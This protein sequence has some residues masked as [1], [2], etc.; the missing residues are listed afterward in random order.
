VKPSLLFESPQSGTGT[1]GED[2][3]RH[4]ALDR[5]AE[6]FCPDGERRKIFLQILASPLTDEKELTFRREIR[7][8]LRNNPDTEPAL[9]EWTKGFAELVRT[10][11]HLRKD[12][13]RE[14]GSA[15]DAIATANNLR[16]AQAVCLKRAILFLRDALSRL[17]GKYESKGILRLKAAL[18]ESA[19]RPE[20]EEILDLC[21]KIE[22]L[23][24]NE[25]EF[26]IVLTEDGEAGQCETVYS[27]RKKESEERK[28]FTLFHREPPRPT[29]RTME[30]L[31]EELICGALRDSSYVLDR[32]CEELFSR[33][34]NLGTELSFYRTV[35][36]YES[37]MQERGAVLSDPEAG[38][39]TRLTG[40]SDPYL[41]LTEGARKVIANDYQPKEGAGT[42]IFG[43]NGG[44][45]TVFLRALMTAQV[46]A[47]AGLPIPAQGSV[48]LYAKMNSVFAEAENDAGTDRAG[49]FEQEVRQIASLLEE[50][51]GNSVFF[52]NEPFQTT[53]PKEGSVGLSAILRHLSSL[54]TDWVTVTHLQDLK[55][56][57][58]GEALVLT[59]REGYR[60]LPE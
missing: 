20:A 39:V 45:K 59:A 35:L 38:T 41:V 40:L 22:N 4:A 11:K 57:L 5:T 42:L 6:R 36:D 58:S 7:N 8:D 21:N 49:R 30:L 27:P 31:S 15:G 23:H 13:R 50:D 55:K 29:F 46:F 44:G 53:D 56:E 43:Q 32:L 14:A 2:L 54:S 28:K 17:S 19:A 33:F 47:Q 52:F 34:E 26:R 9:R 48:R 12:L 3:F 18:E 10:H 16:I 25:T 37:F 24:L 60:I 1:V 51:P